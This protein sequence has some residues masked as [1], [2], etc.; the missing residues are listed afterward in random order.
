MSIVRVI[1]G[2]VGFVAGAGFPLWLSFRMGGPCLGWGL[3]LGCLLGTIGAQLGSLSPLPIWE[4]KRVLIWGSVGGAVVGVLLGIYFIHGSPPKG[5]FGPA[6]YCVSA[7]FALGGFVIPWV[8]LYRFVP[9]FCPRCKGRAYL[10]T[11][12][13]FFKKPLSSY[14]YKCKTCKHAEKADFSADPGT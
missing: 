1:G 2:I 8:V 3:I 4:H 13:T 10:W 11:E 14:S 7:F 12:S 5:E 6:V 9:V